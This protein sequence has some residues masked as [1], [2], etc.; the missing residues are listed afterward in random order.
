[1]RRSTRKR[2]TSRW[3]FEKIPLRRNVIPSPPSHHSDQYESWVERTFAVGTPIKLR[4]TF[5]Y[6]VAQAGTAIPVGGIPL[7]CVAFDPHRV[8]HAPVYAGT[9]LEVTETS[10]GFD[11]ENMEV[12]A[13]II[14]AR[15]PAGV[16]IREILG[17]E[18]EFERPELYLEPLVDNWAPLQAPRPIP[19][20]LLGYGQRSRMKSNP[21]PPAPS[22]LRNFRAWAKITFVPGTPVIFKTYTNAAIV[23]PVHGRTS[24]V[25]TVP[26][27]TRG[28]VVAVYHGKWGGQVYRVG[29]DLEIELHDPRGYRQLDSLESYFWSLLDRSGSRRVVRDIHPPGII[30]IEPLV[31]NWAQYQKPYV[32]RTYRAP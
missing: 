25:G 19:R 5:W 21:I 14:D 16:P 18:M 31:D 9:R 10:R 26:A 29:V 24:V 28:E 20:Y 6:K 7:M 13:R 1:M 4:Q 23:S 15:D 2:R 17:K 8:D 12:R 11:V 32:P 27:G 22:S 30:E 3:R